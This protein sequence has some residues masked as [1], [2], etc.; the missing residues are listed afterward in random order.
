MINQN[1]NITFDSFKFIV[2]KVKE[3][4][5]LDF[6]CDDNQS[7]D[8]FISDQESLLQIFKSLIDEMSVTHPELCSN[9]IVFTPREEQCLM[10][11][12]RGKSAKEV[13]KVLKISH[14]TV[15][16]YLESIK[17]KLGCRN[18]FEIFGKLHNTAYAI[19]LN[20]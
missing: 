11:L 20:T 18:K 5:L 10:Q 2:D 1:L 3:R 7:K 17:Q 4:V 8:K 6:K 9:E 14:R 19:L 16:S 13:G 12:I 15:E